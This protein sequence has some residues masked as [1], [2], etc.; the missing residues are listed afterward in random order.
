M[1]QLNLNKE[2]KYLLACSFGPDSM[3]LFYLLQSQGYQFDCAIVNYHLRNESNSEVDGL[4]KYASL[5]GIKVY[6]L[7]IK[8]KPLKNIEATCRK[9]RYQFF[10]ELTDINGYAATLVAHHQDDLIETYLMQK[11]R[12]NCPIYYGINE[13]TVINSATIIRPLL[14]YSKQDLLNICQ[15]NNVPFSVD[16]TNFD[17]SIKRNKFRH[18]IVS[19]MSQLER[20]ISVKEIDEK[21]IELVNLKNL[22]DRTDLNDINSILCFSKKEINYALNELLV[23]SRIKTPL[24]NNNVGQVISILKSKKPNGEFPIKSGLW[25]I[26][27]YGYFEFSTKKIDAQKYS[28]MLNSPGVLDTDYFHLD[29]S[30]NSLDRNVSI[31][32][33]PITIR[34]I[35]KDDEI[36]IKGYVTEARRLLIDWKVPYRLRLIWPVIINKDNKC[37]YIPRYRKDFVPKKDCNFYV[38]LKK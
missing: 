33:Y 23:K 30:K 31:N 12:Q 4:V 11:D 2:N 35:Q 32:D 34:N 16:K 1:I 5:F 10:K 36:A 22:L 3:A 26:K 38:K 6:V 17:L 18:Q 14:A 29:F 7:D 37:I 21:N 8:D 28:F 25:L 20:E 13:N 15:K 19:K 9:I 24:S 27:E